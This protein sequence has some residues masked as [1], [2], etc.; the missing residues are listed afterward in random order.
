MNRISMHVSMN[1]VGSNEIGKE[2]ER[3]MKM[4]EREHKNN[5]KQDRKT[6]R[7]REIMVPCCKY[8]YIECEIMTFLPSFL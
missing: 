1:T 3:G 2:G 5:R 4:N 7:G 8:V 6:G